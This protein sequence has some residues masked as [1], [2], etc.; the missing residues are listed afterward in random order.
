MTPHPHLV[1]VVAVTAREVRRTPAAHL[2]PDVHARRDQYG[3]EKEDIDT[4]LAVES[5]TE[6]VSSACPGIIDVSEHG[7]QFIHGGLARPCAATRTR[8][9][10]RYSSGKALHPNESYGMNESSV[11]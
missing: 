11:Y 5:V 6:T 2:V 7:E 4:E 1:R 10:Q 8:S 3:E 9:E